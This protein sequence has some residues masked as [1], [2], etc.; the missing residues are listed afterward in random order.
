MTAPGSYWPAPWTCEDGGPRRLGAPQGQPGLGIT[1]GECL[2][3]QTVRDVAGSG[4]LIRREPGELYLLRHEL[5]REPQGRP[6]EAWV[7]RIDPH[8]LEPLAATPKLPGGPYWPGGL[9]AHANGD[10][11]LV[12]GPWAHR[13]TPELEVLASRRLP[14]DRP[15]NSFI[16][17]NGGE[18]V[19]KD[20][21]A[22]FGVTPSTMSVLD[23]LTLEP[24]AAPFPLPEPCIARLASD[25]DSIIAVGSTQV[26]RLTLDREAGRLVMDEDWRPRFG[27]DP[28]RSFGWDPVLSDDHVFWMDNGRNAV[29]M[30]M[31]GS[32]SSSSPVRLW[33]ARHDDDTAHSTEISGLPYGTESNPPGWD[34]V[35]RVVVA[36]D[37]GNAVLRAWRMDGDELEPLWRRDNF[38]HAGHLILFPDT[39]ELVVQDWQGRPPPGLLRR[40]LRPLVLGAGRSAVVRRIAGRTIGGDRLVVLDLDTGLE[41]AACLIPA[42][43]QAFLFPAPGFERDLYYQSITTIARAIVSPSRA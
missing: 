33:W 25:G 17:L 4:M 36:Y 39:R 11:Y 13:I 16:A 9:G 31:L 24:V 8:T 40:V 15:H 12:F 1:G 35:G 41:K 43:M 34:P 37:A 5:P 10:L 19:M 18:L 14:N 27:P 6:V 7:E 32:G 3:L 21:D 20:C 42:P 30:T 22:P 23:P 29:D 28:D 26:F 38:A 2:E